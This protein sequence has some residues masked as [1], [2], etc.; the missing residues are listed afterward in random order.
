MCCR[1]QQRRP[2]RRLYAPAPGNHARVLACHERPL[3]RGSAHAAGRAEGTRENAWQ[4]AQ[5]SW[6][7]LK[8]ERA[9]A[10]FLWAMISLCSEMTDSKGRRARAGW[11]FFDAECAFC[12][13]LARRMA[14]I[15]V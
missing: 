5:D 10:R 9:T 14:R 7:V 15:L 8:E 6:Q 1:G 11:L 4:D 3:R 12:V 2:G 13:A